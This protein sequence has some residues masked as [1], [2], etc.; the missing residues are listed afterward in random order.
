[1]RKA[2]DNQNE[3]HA[4]YKSING[5]FY[6]QIDLENPSMT[7]I[8]LHGSSV[9][10]AYESLFIGDNLENFS[11]YN[12]YAAYTVGYSNWLFD[13]GSYPEFGY[14]LP[15]KPSILCKTFD[16]NIYTGFFV[17][18]SDPAVESI[19]PDS[20]AGLFESF[21]SDDLGVSVYQNIFNIGKTE[22]EDWCSGF[23]RIFSKVE[24]II[25]TP[26]DSCG[27]PILEPAVLAFT[28]PE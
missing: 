17:T 4:I 11:G 8:K 7:W 18:V 3:I 1:M 14:I 25:Q 28:P 27:V 21:T 19:I 6:L 26:S 12:L 2:H 22:Y 13:F 15:S 9:S 5:I 23:T 10:E 20:Q 24:P 16:G